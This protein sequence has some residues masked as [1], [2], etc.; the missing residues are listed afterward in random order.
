MS[1]DLA[2][3]HS[4][5]VWNFLLKAVKDAGIEK[6][7]LL[8]ASAR[9]LCEVAK[10]VNFCTFKVAVDSRTYAKA[11]TSSFVFFSHNLFSPLPRGKRK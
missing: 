7:V 6:D 1:G 11:L 2:V 3:A 8:G 10:I 4:Q 9:K 5:A